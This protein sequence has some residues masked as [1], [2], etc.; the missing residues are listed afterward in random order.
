[1][2]RKFQILQEDSEFDEKSYF[3]IHSNFFNS[4]LD[5]NNDEGSKKIVHPIPIK[6]INIP[7]LTMSAETFFTQRDRSQQIANDNPSADIPDSDCII[8][9]ST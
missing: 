7:H 9:K 2:F 6:A 5:E 3:D 8:K 1:M 4:L